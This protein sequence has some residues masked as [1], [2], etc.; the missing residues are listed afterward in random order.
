[1]R[2]RS[3]LFMLAV[4]ASLSAC[5]VRQDALPPEVRLAD[6]RPVGIGLIEQRFQVILRLVNRNDF[7]LNLDGMT[8]DLELNGQPFAFGAS[9]QAVSLPRLGQATVP[10]EVSATLLEIT[11]SLL[12]V[13]DSG[14]V[15]YRISGQAYMT[16]FAG[17]GSD[18]VPYE[19][20]GSIALPSLGGLLDR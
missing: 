8:L 9:N 7:A 12:S 2:I 16:S 13:A 4:A 3:I 11:Q 19:H 10:I 14:S 17:L 20:A 15:S 6:L 1:M 18:T 5:A